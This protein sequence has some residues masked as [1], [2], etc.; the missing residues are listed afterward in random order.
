MER[1]LRLAFSIFM[2]LIIALCTVSWCILE[3]WNLRLETSTFKIIRAWKHKY[4]S[5]ASVAVFLLS[6]VNSKSSKIH[7]LILICGQYHVSCETLRI[8]W[9]DDTTCSTRVPRVLSA[10]GWKARNPARSGQ[11]AW[12]SCRAGCVVFSENPKGLATHLVLLF[13]TDSW[14]MVPNFAILLNL[15]ANTS[16]IKY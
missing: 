14:A 1:K 10:T 11:H 3:G 12:H 7:K 5:V 16:R 13:L 8:F 4:I 9:N 2:S 6:T 15:T